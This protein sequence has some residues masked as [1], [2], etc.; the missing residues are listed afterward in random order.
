MIVKKDK[1]FTRKPLLF[2]F[3]NKRVE[4]VPKYSG[5]ADISKTLLIIRKK[6]CNHESNNS[7][8]LAARAARSDM[9]RGNR[10]NFVGNE[11]SQIIFCSPLDNDPS[12][13]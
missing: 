12:F 9:P 4:I 3:L 13:P 8:F 2:I 6:N 1:M 5:T 11:L 10:Y 7:C